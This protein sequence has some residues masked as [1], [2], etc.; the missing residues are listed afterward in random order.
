MNI[1]RHHGYAARTVIEAMLASGEAA[2]TRDELEQL[3]FEQVMQM[4]RDHKDVVLSD[5]AHA[6]R[7]TLLREHPL[8]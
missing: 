5:Q 6:M 2:A 7:A 1:T 4:L 8:A 3:P